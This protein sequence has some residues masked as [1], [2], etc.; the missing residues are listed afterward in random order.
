MQAAIPGA[1]DTIRRAAA[2]LW[3]SAALVLVSILAGLLDP[4]GAANL[5]DAVADLVSLGLLALVAWKLPQGR[6][7]ARWV[8]AIVVALGVL[9]V[10]T[11]ILVFPDVWQAMSGVLRAYTI[12]QTALQVTALGLAFTPGA[13]AWFRSP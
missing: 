12:I 1:P 10:V 3:A 4:D 6:D 7:W 9:S 5:P 13:K 11:S 2:L 8:L